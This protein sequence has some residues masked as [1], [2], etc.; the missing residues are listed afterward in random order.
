[1]ARMY[2]Q[3]ERMQVSNVADPALRRQ[4]PIS[5]ISG[6]SQNGGNDIVQDVRPKIKEIKDTSNQ[7][8]QATSDVQGN[9][10]QEQQQHE[11]QQ[12]QQKQPVENG[13]SP[14]INDPVS[15]FLDEVVEQVVDNIEQR[16]KFKDGNGKTA[17]VEPSST[18]DS[19]PNPCLMG[20]HTPAIPVDSIRKGSSTS[21]H[22]SKAEM[23]AAKKEADLTGL[24]NQATSTAESQEITRPPSI[25]YEKQSTNTPSR[26]IFSPGPRAPPFRIPEF[27]WSYLHQ[28]LLSDLLFSLEQDIQV[29]KTQAAT[30][31]FVSFI[32]LLL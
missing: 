2:Q 4:L 21:E 5:T 14:E 23:E 24:K 6:I 12:E 18:M 19:D 17:D 28:K 10:P 29:W 26:Q 22:E 9:G 16:H 31:T 8:T 30:F 11:Q 20:N 13:K 1:M 27:R 3:Y 32:Y 25:Q 7:S 15:S